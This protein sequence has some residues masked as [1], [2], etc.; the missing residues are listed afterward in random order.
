MKPLLLP[1]IRRITRILN[2]RRVLAIVCCAIWLGY[3]SLAGIAHIHHAAGDHHVSM[4]LHL[5]HTHID[6]ATDP[7][8][9]HGHLLLTDE[10]C[11]E[12]ADHHGHG[13]AYMSDGAVWLP[14]GAKLLPALLPAAP[15]V[16]SVP[17]WIASI[18]ARP[19][20]PR[21]P[22]DRLLPLLRAPPA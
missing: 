3:G 20:N 11:P 22:P 9:D 6:H 17:T 21:D 7:G 4:G 8:H 10:L 18:T 2:M 5:D 19:D 13:I 12:Q 1:Q 14:H 16:E 15:M